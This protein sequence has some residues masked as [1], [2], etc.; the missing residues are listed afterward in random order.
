MCVV[1]VEYKQKKMIRPFYI[2]KKTS[3]TSNF[4]N[5]FDL[6]IKIPY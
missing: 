5:I 4:I 6:P 1:Y 3:Q 2:L